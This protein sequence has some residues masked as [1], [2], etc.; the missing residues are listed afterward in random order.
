[1]S[2]VPSVRWRGRRLA[3]SCVDVTIVL[4]PVAAASATMWTLADELGAIPVVWRILAL[5]AASSL[6]AYARRACGA[7]TSA[8]EHAAAAHHGVSGPCAVAFQRGT[9]GR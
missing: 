1:M 6:A 4:V 5:L 2:A 8:V 9:S 3:A 7:S